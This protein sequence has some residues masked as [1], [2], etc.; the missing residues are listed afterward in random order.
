M[1]RG[2]FVEARLDKKVRI[3]KK[4]RFFSFSIIGSYTF[5]KIIQDH[6]SA[7]FNLK[8][9]GKFRGFFLQIQSKHRNAFK[10]TFAL[11]YLPFGQ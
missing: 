8:I 6:H 11:Q 3:K 10:N 1:K 5:I 7:N 4:D 2:H 9:L